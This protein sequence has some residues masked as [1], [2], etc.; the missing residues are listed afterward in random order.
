MTDSVESLKTGSSESGR[1]FAA[2]WI[3]LAVLIVWLCT[4]IYIV[5]SDEVAV[6]SVFGKAQRTPDGTLQIQ[7]SGLYYQWPWPLGEVQRVRLFEPRTLTVGSDQDEDS[8]DFLQRFSASNDS[9]FISG[10]KNILN[11]E[12]TVHYRLSRTDLDSW[13]FDAQYPEA[14][15][16]AVVE[17]TMSDVILR[18]GVDFVHTLGHASIRQTIQTS[19]QQR[20]AELKLGVEIDDVSIS[21]VKPPIRVKAE[22]IDVMNARADRATYINRANAY[23][24]QQLASAQ[25]M[26]Q[27]LANEAEAFQQKT[28]ESAKA[29]ADSFEA[30][31]DQFALAGQSDS[32]SYATARKLTVERRYIDMLSKVYRNVAGKVF[33]D[34]GKQV[35]ITIHRKP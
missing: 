35:D 3:V 10:D 6:V 11:V 8:G 29:E 19:L 18:S 33:L 15:L 23:A 20:S 13:L 26:S 21:G 34:S 22:F 25:A 4:G 17:A 16:R 30:I 31:V 28:I 9:R 2:R 5:P 7:E 12:L 24:E 1:R 32:G 14:R 27:K